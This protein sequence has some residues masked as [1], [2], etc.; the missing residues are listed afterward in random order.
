MAPGAHLNLEFNPGAFMKRVTFFLLSLMLFAAPQV[1][2]ADDAVTKAMK[3]FEK[4]HY[5]EAVAALRSDAAS[6]D[7][8]RQGAAN[9]TLGT[10][11]LKNALLHRE[12]FQ[13]AASAS[14]DYLKKLAASQGPARSRFVDFY[15]GEA[16]VE[17]GKPAVA[18][19]YL[20]KFS[21]G[22]K[23]EARYRSAAKVCLGLCYYQNH[24]VQKAAELW[25]AIDPSDPE[26]KAELAAA[27]S[28]AGLADKNPAALADESLAAVKRTGK[29]L[30]MRMVK[31]LLAVYARSG[32]TEK[33]LDLITRSDLKAYSYRET[34]GKSKII[35]FYDLALLGDMATIYGQ[36]SISYLEKAAADPKVKDAA[37][38]YLGQSYSLFGSLD[39][40][41]K[42]M[43]S[44]VSS[45]QVPQQYKD[46]VRVWQ[47]ATLYQKGR[48]PD[49]VGVW[50]ELLRKQPEDPEL[51]AEL[52][53]A[54]SRLRAE[55]SQTMK[56]SAA[57]VE[58]GEG[59]KISALNIAVGTFYLGKMDYA[60]AASYLE[61]GRD[62]GNKNKIEANDPAMLVDLAEAYY[63]TKKFSEALEI[64]FEMSKHFPE[65]RQIQEVLQGI[66]AMEHK[67]A[68]DVKIN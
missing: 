17:A 27:Y 28:R 15:L 31:N 3:L 5:Q 25:S 55:C 1:H 21:A 41:A 4:R 16:L 54:C 45:P 24:E 7:R 34:L 12:L 38:F 43:A 48:V 13:V 35:N 9:L 19:I 65:V 11:Y 56:K 50:D 32:L 57:A 53:F 14:Q 10:A 68:G 58:A 26:V 30:S 23:G 8:S 36:A 51:L 49:A 67:S 47:G 37:E 42:V 62:K 18:A 20:E 22:E 39:Q 6:I 66:Y 46:R 60:R 59:K 29:P 44:L 33:G 63:R 61:A 64:Y 2:G 52:L 40:S